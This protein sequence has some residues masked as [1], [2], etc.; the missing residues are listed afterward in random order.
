MALRG[1]C[2]KSFELNAVA[3]PEFPRKPQLFENI[4]KVSEISENLILPKIKTQ[5][6]QRPILM[7]CC[8]LLLWISRQNDTWHSQ[9][10]LNI[11][12]LSNRVNSISWWVTI[13]LNWKLTQIGFGAGNTGV[14]N[15]H[16]CF[17]SGVL[18]DKKWQT[19]HSM[20]SRLKTPI[21]LQGAQS[22]LSWIRAVADLGFPT[23]KGGGECQLRR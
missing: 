1:T 11:L 2:R 17:K 4:S 20:N 10:T 16:R 18:I 13:R 23:W 3:D 5:K 6:K 12:A 15:W 19:L 8:F 7:L 14:K 22:F 21:T 9:K